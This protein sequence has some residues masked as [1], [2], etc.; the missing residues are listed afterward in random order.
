MDKLAIIDQMQLS[1]N[2]SV[3]ILSHF[4]KRAEAGGGPPQ[5]IRD[6]LIPKVNKLYYIEHPFL[7]SGDHRS[8]LTIYEDGMVKSLMFTPQIF[9]PGIT[10][11]IIEIII[12]WYFLLLTKT[13]FDLCVALDNL[14]TF[15]VLPFRK[16]GLVKKLVFYTIDYMPKR[17]EN[18][19]LNNIYHLIDRIACYHSDNIWILS[20]RMIKARK[21]N[22][23]D[24]KRSAPSIL[25]PMGA[26]LSEI[27]ILPGK[28]IHRHDIVYVGYLTEKQGVQLVLK[29]LPKI[30]SKIPDLKF[31]II[32]QGEYE[33][34]LRELSNNLNIN[35]H[36]IFK[37]FVDD[38]KQVN[39]ILCKSAIGVAPYPPILN[40]YT[41]YTDPGKPKLYLGC[42]LPVVI[43]DL[44]AIAHVIQSAHAGL[45]VDYTVNSIAEAL[46][47][48]LSDDRLYNMF[49]KNAIELSKQ[50]DTNSLISEAFGK[51]N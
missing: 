31:I 50:Y 20:E 39:N 22:N 49:R 21:Q 26:N 40:N 1:K 41:F 48:L 5:D 37:G 24:I 2:S 16:F 7:Y 6:Y 32:G 28:K 29:S 25:L 34:K 51:I 43:T 23:V 44:P 11:Y 4:A 8:S 33:Q 3:L 27:K 17:F 47:T 35:N 14:N 15:T 12:T 46:V 42:G 10:I 13:K 18:K 38:H 9:G 36:V 19:T 30:I 45:I